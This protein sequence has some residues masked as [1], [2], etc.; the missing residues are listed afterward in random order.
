MTECDRTWEPE[1]FRAICDPSSEIDRLRAINAELLAALEAIA[2]DTANFE[3]GD[4]NLELFV[5]GLGSKAKAARD[6]ARKE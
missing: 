1:D 6:K 3:H 5:R 2:H 4:A